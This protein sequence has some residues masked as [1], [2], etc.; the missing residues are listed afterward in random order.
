LLKQC[1]QSTVELP[2]PG[3]PLFEECK[4]NDQLYSIDWKDYDMKNP[5][6][7]T[8]FPKE[9]LLKLVQSLYSVSYNPEFIVRKILSIRDIDDI[10]Y[11]CRAFLKVARHILD[12]KKG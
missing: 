7:K 6:M 2:Y 8:D 5:I 12:F 1:S 10:K 11:F 4:T 3:T 9:K